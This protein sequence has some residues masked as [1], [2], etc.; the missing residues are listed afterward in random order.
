MYGRDNL[1]QVS[2]DAVLTTQ[3]ASSKTTSIPSTQSLD[4]EIVTATF[5]LFRDLNSLCKFKV[6][7]K[8]YVTEFTKAAVY[9]V[10]VRTSIGTEARG[11]QNNNP[12]DNEEASKRQ[13]VHVTVGP[14]VRVTRTATP[15]TA[16]STSESV[17]PQTTRRRTTCCL[18]SYIE[19]N[20]Q[21]K[22][23]QQ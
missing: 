3:L 5:S 9:L 2:L 19:T 12:N 18:L 14:V 10:E 23:Q 6:R 11:I 13:R 20:Q 8:G 17:A 15:I 22:K 7:H 16:A 4:N 21:G 1:Q